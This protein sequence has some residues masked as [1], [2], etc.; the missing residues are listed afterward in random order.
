MS[1][2]VWNLTLQYV[3]ENKDF[4]LFNPLTGFKTENPINNV[5]V[6]FP[7]AEYV[8]DLL[9]SDLAEKINQKVTK[10]SFNKIKKA[11]GDCQNRMYNY[12]FCGK[13]L[14]VK[15]N[16][17]LYIKITYI[18]QVLHGFDYI[19]K[20]S[21]EIDALKAVQKVQAIFFLN[22]NHT[23]EIISN[24]ARRSA[25]QRNKEFREHFKQKQKE[26]FIKNPNLTANS[27][28]CQFYSNPT[29]TIPYSKQNQLNS[30]I[31]LAQANNREFKNESGL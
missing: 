14:E 3:R 10:S 6:S 16:D 17:V 9:I 24:Q 28:A 5:W 18:F 4:E 1:N 29:M 19:L 12:L 11:V 8:R 13:E 7:S 22:D 25:Q 31:R 27:F 20:Q 2:D 21:N 15:E 30:L 26:E 23:E